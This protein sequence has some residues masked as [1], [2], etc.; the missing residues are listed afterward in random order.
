MKSAPCHTALKRPSRKA[1]LVSVTLLTAASTP[2]IPDFV[3]G[4]LLAVRIPTPG[5]LLKELYGV[6][7]NKF[8]GAR[9][10]GR[11]EELDS[12]APRSGAVPLKGRL[13]LKPASIALE[14]P[15]QLLTGEPTSG[16]GENHHPGASAKRGS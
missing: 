15:A 2:I 7:T 13:T 16:K 5:T 4:R 11:E 1:S 12:K 10:C 14:R 9:N 3:S 6:P 8:D